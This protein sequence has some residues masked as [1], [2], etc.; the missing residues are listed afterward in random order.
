M[1]KIKDRNIKDLT[2]AEEIKK[3]R[4]EYTEEL[5]KKILNDPDNH[6]GMVTH[7]ES[8]ILE[9]EVK[10]DLGSLTTKKAQGGDRIPA[11]L[12]KIL[13]DDAIK[14]LHFMCQQI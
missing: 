3:R 1:G 4:Q 13:K 9:C 14:L 6:D 8:D 11:E 12:L 2:E 10:W 5:Y 7:L